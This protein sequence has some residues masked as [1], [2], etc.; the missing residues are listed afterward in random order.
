M[1]VGLGGDVEVALALATALAAELELPPT[2]AAD[3]VEPLL[4]APPPPLFPASLEQAPARAAL[5]IVMPSKTWLF[6]MVLPFR[7][8]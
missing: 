6:L 7:I 3:E 2:P 1:D 4:P 8:S 5:R